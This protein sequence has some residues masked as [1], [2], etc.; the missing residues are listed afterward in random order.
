M[1][2]QIT[3]ILLRQRMRIAVL[4]LLSCISG[5]TMGQYVAPG[6]GQPAA[7]VKFRFSAV[8]TIPHAEFYLRIS[9]RSGESSWQKIEDDL[10]SE[11]NQSNPL[12]AM[13]ATAVPEAE[14]RFRM[15]LEYRW[16]VQELDYQ[17][18]YH[19]GEWR[20]QPAWITKEKRK[21][22]RA[23]VTFH[24]QSEQSYLLDYTSLEPEKCQIVVYRQEFVSEI[25]EASVSDNP[26]NTSSAG[27][28]GSPES[29]LEA[30]ETPDNSDAAS[31]RLVPVIESTE[32]EP[33]PYFAPMEW[34][35]FY[36]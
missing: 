29:G 23:Y 16:R 35:R 22:C 9:V 26:S 18:F 33:L 4:C 30:S 28:E 10:E 20:Q 2:A 32:S 17:T 11:P 19:R 25:T 12:F 34:G 7:L 1:K 8:E 13:Y 5:C 6:P 15:D 24:P 14:W 31:W 36:W 3:S 27:K 21:G